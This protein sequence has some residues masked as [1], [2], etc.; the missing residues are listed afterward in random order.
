MRHIAALFVTVLVLVSSVAVAQESLRPDVP[1]ALVGGMLLDGYEAAPIHDAVVVLQSR[2]GTT[3]VP[4]DQYYTGY[5]QSVRRPEQL[6]RAIR[7]PRRERPREFEWFHKVGARSAQALAQVG[8]AMVK[9]A[10]GWRVVANSVAPTVCRC[11]GLEAALD[12]G[13]SFASPAEIVDILNADISPIDDL[14]STAEYRKRVLSR[15]IYFRLVEREKRKEKR[16]N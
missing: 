2:D 6:I 12:A 9:D 4:L 1:V 10:A 15:L 13:Q 16:E 14:R 8:V 3:E 11:R 7:M 5:K